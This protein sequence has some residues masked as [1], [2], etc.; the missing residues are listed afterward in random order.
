MYKDIRYFSLLAFTEPSPVS[1]PIESKP[2]D[3]ITVEGILKNANRK[4]PTASSMRPTLSSG[5]QNSM[6]GSYIGCGET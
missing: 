1:H 2:S 3:G 4:T 5:K 6:I